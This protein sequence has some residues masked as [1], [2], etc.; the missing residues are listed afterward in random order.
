MEKIKVC[1]KLAAFLGLMV[2]I[3]SGCN[4]PTAVLHLVEPGTPVYETL[5]LDCST[6]GLVEPGELIQPAAGCDSWEINRYE[7]PFNPGAQ[8]VYYPDLDVLYAEL[9]R[10]ETWF[11]LNLALYDA[12]EDAEQLDGTYGIEI[13][14]DRDNRGD[15]LIAVE[16]PGKVTDE[17]WSTLRVQV[18]KDNNND[19]GNEKPREPDL[20]YLG[21]GYN[22]LVFDQGE[23][24][25]P[26]AAWAR[27]I[28][29]QSA[30]VGIAFK[31]SL[32]D[33]PDEFVW[34]VWSDQGVVNPAG[35]DYHDTY[36]NEKAGDAYESE[37][38]FP[39][40]QVNK[41]DNTC[42]SL[43][44]LPPD[45]DPSLCIN[46]LN[47]AF[48]EGDCP[49]LEFDAFLDWFYPLYGGPPL[50]PAME[51]KIYEFYKFYSGC[52]EGGRPTLTPTSSPTNTPTST[53]ETATFTQETATNTPETPTPTST[54]RPC[55]F[56]CFCEPNQ[57]ETE[58]NCPKDCPKHCGN[59]VCDCG[60]TS[61]TCKK[62]C[63]SPPD[64]TDPGDPGGGCSCGDG[65]CDPAC[66]ENAN[67]CCDCSP[68]G[69]ACP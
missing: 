21:D 40:D 23:G 9:G 58:Y 62:D 15:I 28:L 30:Y 51:A 27:A 29:G 67:N 69:A 44:G 31:A 41:L 1:G 39:S 12:N 6:A 64:N 10:D 25:D 49:P 66:G 7:R 22:L 68:A 46:D 61:W 35:F 3:L 54:D 4:Y 26:D 5:L 33:S 34:W 14:W 60:E 43:W 56:D 59:D 20:P 37:P 45:E 17:E 47:F 57:G 52:G 16:Q 13:D 55:D 65:V 63:G 19:V 2:I 36:D 24:S 48:L 38:Y 8:D 53:R 42:S 11:Y 32:L 18:W 50:P